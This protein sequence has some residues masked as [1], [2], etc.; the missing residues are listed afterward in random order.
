MQGGDKSGVTK[1]TLS[2]PKG[3]GSIEGV[4]ALLVDS[5]DDVVVG[6]QIAVVSDLGKVHASAEKTSPWGR[7]F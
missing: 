2:V 4:G 1:K 3:A 5:P 7:V 6:D